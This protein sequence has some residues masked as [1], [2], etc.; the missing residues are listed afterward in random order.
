M[1]I[2][3]HTQVHLTDALRSYVVPVEFL[4]LLA[5]LLWD[6]KSCK[7][8]ATYNIYTVWSDTQWLLFERMRLSSI[9]E[10]KPV[11]LPNPFTLAFFSADGV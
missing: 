5:S 9:S 2:A 11:N 6:S 3:G 4:I 7:Y 10:K 8:A 1:S